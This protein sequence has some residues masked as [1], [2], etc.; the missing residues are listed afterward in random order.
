M[1]ARQ[2]LDW[3]GRRGVSVSLENHDLVFAGDASALSPKVVARLR[4]LKSD[5]VAELTRQQGQETPAGPTVQT[6]ET[7][8]SI[9]CHGVG[10]MPWRG[11]EGRWYCAEHVPPRD[12]SE[13]PPAVQDNR[14]AT[15]QPKQ[16]DG[17]LELRNIATGETTIINLRAKDAPQRINREVSKR[18]E[19]H[20]IYA[21]RRSVDLHDPSFNIDML[22]DIANA[23]N[24][25]AEA[26]GET[27]RYCRCGKFA[28]TQW[29][30]DKKLIWFCDE[31][32]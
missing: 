25:A 21:Q 14:P 2:A 29:R 5:L 17:I 13:K 24:E 8:G 28:S 12:A 7:C 11:I 10:A 1:T 31:C 30:L 19:T 6:C 22:Q 23:R 15:T 27:S 26:T 9:A 3:L 20:I 4:S 18:R 16:R 32:Y